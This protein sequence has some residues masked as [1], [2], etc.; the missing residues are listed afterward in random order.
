MPNTLLACYELKASCVRPL[1]TSLHREAD[2]TAGSGRGGKR[3]RIRVGLDVHPASCA[4]ALMRINLK[5]PAHVWVLQ[6]HRLKPS[7]IMCVCVTPQYY[8][9]PFQAI[10]LV[11]YNSG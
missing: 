2:T 10:D 9:S 7:N 11:N 5:L 3:L 1:R 4:H 8:R 6:W